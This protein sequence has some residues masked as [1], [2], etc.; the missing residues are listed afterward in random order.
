MA[1]REGCLREDLA[2]E[3]PFGDA[4]QIIAF[5][6]FLLIWAADSF[7]LKAS[8]FPADA[9]PFYVRLIL[10]APVFILAGYLLRSGHNV[11]F[12]EVREKPRVIR[13]GVFSISRHPIY[14]SALLFYLVFFLTTLSLSSLV[15]L[16]LI[17]VFY[18]VIAAYEER[19]MEARFGDEYREYKERTR[20]WI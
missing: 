15:F 10:A 2:G 1:E 16:G 11:V 13:N 18:N 12:K 4:G 3:H 19:L 5:T 6:L 17:F 20:R 14:L 8:T 9:V 7:F